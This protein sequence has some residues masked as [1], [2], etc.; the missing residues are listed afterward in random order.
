MDEVEKA[1]RRPGRREKASGKPKTD[2]V[3][4]R[5]RADMR[6]KLGDSAKA[7]DLSISEEVER[8]CLLSFDLASNPSNEYIIR[9]VADALR[10]SEIV[11]GRSWT[12]DRTTAFMACASMQAAAAIIT[13]HHE[14]VEQDKDFANLVEKAGVV[15]AVRAAALYSGMPIENLL[16]IG[17]DVVSSFFGARVMREGIPPHIMAQALRNGAPAK[18]AATLELSLRSA[19]PDELDE[20]KPTPGQLPPSIGDQALFDDAV[21]GLPLVKAEK[22]KPAEPPAP[23]PA[24]APAPRRRARAK[25]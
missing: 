1:Q 21:S 6:Q 11:T 5:V 12:T 13:A 22:A 24:P 8:R 10:L 16:E 25:A 20:M 2:T 7:R 3:T 15:Q 23:S 18:P 14:G 9:T 19:T 17:R 4:F